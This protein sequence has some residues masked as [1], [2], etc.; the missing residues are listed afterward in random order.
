MIA[1]TC[2][3]T[4][5]LVNS[6]WCRFRPALDSLGPHRVNSHTVTVKVE[7]RDMEALRRAVEG[8]GGTWIGIGTHALYSGHTATGVGFRL[9]DWRYP[10]ALQADGVLAYDNFNGHWGDPAALDRLK[11][12][13]TMAVC[14]QSATAQG[15]LCERS[16]TGELLIHHPDGGTMTVNAAG[17]IDAAGF[18]GAACHDAIMS[19]GLPIL[20]AQVKPEFSQVA[21]NVQVAQ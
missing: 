11:A 19:M 16:A 20:D 17:V 8:L 10:L 2:P 18:V 15:W 1:F 7:Y 6:R 13:Y 21:A 3:R 5:P 12:E 9:P 4:C 14:E